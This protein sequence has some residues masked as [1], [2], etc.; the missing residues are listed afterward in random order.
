MKYENRWIIEKML[1][2]GGQGEV[3]LV[4]K[5][6][7][8]EHQLLG[9]LFKAWP[10]AQRHMRL[11]QRAEAQSLAANLLS[12]IIGNRLNVVFGA[13]KVLHQQ[14]NARDPKTCAAAS[15]AGN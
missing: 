5:K 4:R 13:L 9:Q 8:G 12:Q 7:E 6:A 3:S 14:G 10:E 11:E 2:R 1:G 15:S